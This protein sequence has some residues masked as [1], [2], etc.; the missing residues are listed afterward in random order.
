MRMEFTA[1]G[2]VRAVAL[3]GIAAALIGNAACTSEPGRPEIFS[4]SGAVAL[5]LEGRDPVGNFTEL[6]PV[7]NPDSVRVFLYRGSH[8]HDS[9]FTAAGA[10]GFR[11]YD[12][13]FYA[14]ATLPGVV[15][16]SAAFTIAGADVQIPDTLELSTL[17][18]T[19]TVSPNPFAMSTSIQFPIEAAGPATVTIRSLA[20]SRLRLIAA[21]NFPQGLHMV[22]WDGTDDADDPVADGPYVAVVADADSVRSEIIFKCSSGTCF[23]PGPRRRGF[24]VS[25]RR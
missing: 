13:A 15:A 23:P 16:D 22:E 17:G 6:L 24:R 11:Q 3:A 25:S 10:F 20:G 4:V 9:T 5:Q 18:G 1:Q 21:E 14:V 12:A 19:V 8:L 7:A 2:G